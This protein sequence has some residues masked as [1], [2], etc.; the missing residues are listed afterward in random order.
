VN[1]KQEKKS[2]GKQE[3][4]DLKEENIEKTRRGRK[5]A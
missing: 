2:G 5:N 1:I 4:N 3:E